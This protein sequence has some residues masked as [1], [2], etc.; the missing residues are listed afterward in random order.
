[1]SEK[2]T[3]EKLTPLDG[4]LNPCFCCPPIPAK[5][6]LGKI[7]A[8]GFGSAVATCD[9]ML[10]VDGENGLLCP[11]F[12]GADVPRRT[13]E[14]ITFEDIERIAQADPGHDWQIRLDGPMHGET[15]QRQGENLWLLVE[16]NEGFA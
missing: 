4:R 3:W 9:G 1:M 8:V 10:V 6:E 16:K 5:A 7:I 15:Y 12:W 13:E 11:P 14:F 2:T